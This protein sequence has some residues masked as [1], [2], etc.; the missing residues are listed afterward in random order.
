MGLSAADEGQPPLGG[1]DME[2]PMDTGGSPPGTDPPGATLSPRHDPA[3]SGRVFAEPGSSSEPM[4]EAV[5]AEGEAPGRPIVGAGPGTDISE[6][7]AQAESGSSA[8]PPISQA[9]PREI[10]SWPG[11]P[12]SADEAARRVLIMFQSGS[13]DVCPTSRAG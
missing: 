12:I 7:A 1:G 9:V 13:G 6:Q 3:A 2:V 10:G 8:V 5:H 11:G 4:D